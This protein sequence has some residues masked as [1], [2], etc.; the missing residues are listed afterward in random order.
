[1]FNWLQSFNRAEES[2]LIG[3]TSPEMQDGRLN[4]SS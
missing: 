2:L 3:M 1:V 4:F